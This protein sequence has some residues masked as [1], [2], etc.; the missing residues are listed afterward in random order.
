MEPSVYAGEELKMKVFFLIFFKETKTYSHRKETFT[1]RSIH[2][3]QEHSG[4]CSP[5]N[6]ELLEEK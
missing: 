2:K 6:S 5:Q 3:V 4:R 1:E